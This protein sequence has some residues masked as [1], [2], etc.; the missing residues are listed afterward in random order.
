MSARDSEPSTDD[1]RGRILAVVPR[2]RRFCV[3]LTRSPDSGDDLAQATIERALERSELWQEGT[4]LDSWMFKVAR[5][6]HVDEIRAERR[7]G[8]VIGM[9]ALDHVQGEDG[10]RTVED[11]SDL[12]RAREAI[13][14]LP[15]DQRILVAL[16]IIDGRPYKEAAAVLGI[17]IGTVMSRLA[18]ARISIGSFVNSTSGVA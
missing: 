10:R 13:L 8:A 4:R 7:H 14:A 1:I 3:A 18:R 2:L 16:V 12:S 5:N 15:E 6:L 11:R 17:P 9:D